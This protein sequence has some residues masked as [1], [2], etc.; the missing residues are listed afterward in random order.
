V[1]RW[2]GDEGA[3]PHFA[4]QVAFVDQSFVGAGDG[5]GGDA[6]TRGEASDGWQAIAWSERAGLDAAAELVDELLPEWVA[7]AS[8]AIE[9][10][11]EGVDGRYCTAWRGN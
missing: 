5:L 6:Q 11:F 3:A 7:A 10:Q 8:G 1:Q 2:G 4:A 9:G